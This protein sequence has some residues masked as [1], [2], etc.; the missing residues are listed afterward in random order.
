ML[1]TY[2]AFQTEYSQV[3]TKNWTEEV[4]KVMKNAGL[5]QKSTVFLFS[6][7]Q[8]E[9]E[10]MLEQ[11]CNILNNGEIPNLFQ[12]EERNK[13]IEEISAIKPV[14]SPNEKYQFF[15]SLC[16]KN[17]HMVICMSPV[18]EDFRRRLRTFPSLVN[19][20]TIDWFLPWP[21]EAL[22]STADNHFLSVMKIEDEQTRKGLVK[23]CVDMQ[24]RVT[25]LT[26]RYYQ[27]LRRY[28]YVTPT[29]YLELLSTLHRLLNERN[30]MIQNQIKRYQ[31]GVN[32]IS[33][34]EEEVY[35]MQ[36]ELNELQPKL[37]KATAENKTLLAN[38]QKSQKDAD[39]KK[40]VCEG[41]EKECNIQRDEANKMEAD[42]KRDLDEV[43][44][45]LDE[46]AEALDKISQEDMTQLKSYVNPPVS[47]SVVMEG[48]CYAF[49]EDQN[50]KFTPKEPGSLEKIQD[51]WGYSKKNLLNAKLI[52]RVKD[53][54]EEKIKAIP[55]AKIQKLKVFIQK[56]EF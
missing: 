23:I 53:F 28:Y 11:V 4:Q 12:A 15:V 37:E 55:A 17:L 18:G 52:N 32:K 19:C 56:P 16:K 48:I 10:S 14:G 51:F 30:T 25:E 3:D 20:T 34:T 31:S 41:E 26:E 29:S 13:I 2:I 33:T 8:V 38:L 6:D 9:K 46:A 7:T 22:I 39:A 47:A 45:A 27:E 49:N 44:P 40:A 21:E 1:S 24:V 42:C 54:K 5:E 43:L 36:E 50:I 35:K